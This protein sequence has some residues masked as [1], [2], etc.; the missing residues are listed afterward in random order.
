MAYRAPVRWRVNQPRVVHET[1]DG[2][3]VLIDMDTGSY[4]SLDG[5][6]ADVWALIETGAAT[7]DEIV[8][9]IGRRYEG[10]R[11]EVE[12]AAVRLLEELRQEELIVAD[13]TD[14]V[15]PVAAPAG[16]DDEVTEKRRFEAPALKK[17]TDVQELLLLDPIHEVD[18]TGWPNRSPNP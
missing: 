6:G 4:Y 15:K 2:E 7:T 12:Q 5:V 10:D 18:D 16:P 8:G 3:V 13:G 17:Y 9:E 11:L 14:A 1:L